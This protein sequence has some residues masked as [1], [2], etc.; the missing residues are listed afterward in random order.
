MINIKGW[1]TMSIKT[2]L[3]HASLTLGLLHA[4]STA[5]LSINDKDLELSTNLDLNHFSNYADSTRYFLDSYYI[6]NGED[7]LFAIGLSAH[8]QLQ[9]VEALTLGFGTR[10]IIADDF[11]A[12]PLVAMMEYALPFNAS[13]PPTSLISSF[14]YAPSVLTFDDGESY[15]EFRLESAMQVIQNVRVFVGYR[16]INTKYETYDMRFNESAYGG[17]KLS[18]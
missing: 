17:L 9:G 1:L 13:V 3:L 15:S 7:N 8:N 12:L 6:D 16:N 14:A 11:N 4:Q 2:L 18:F 5:G 10:F